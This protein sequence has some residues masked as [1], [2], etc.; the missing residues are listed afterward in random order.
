MTHPAA[1]P[2]PGHEPEPAPDTQPGSGPSHTPAPPPPPTLPRQV[3]PTPPVPPSAAVL[4][5]PP[6][7]APPAAPPRPA[8]SARA[9][10]GRRVEAA[11]AQV[12][13]SSL[14]P[15][16]S[17]VIRIGFAFTWLCFLLREWPH[18]RQLYGPDGPFSVDMARQLIDGNHAFTM[19]VWSDSTVWFEIVYA[20]AIVSSAL[21][22][23]GWRTRTMSVLFM[24]GVLSLQ[25]RSVFLGDGGDNVIH[26]MSTYLVLTRCGQV[27]SLDARR[28]ARQGA[29]GQPRDATGVVLWAGTGLALAA[30]QMFTDSQLAWTANG[31]LPGL[32]WAAFLWGLWCVQALWWLV[33]RYAPGEPRTVL[34]AVAHLIHNGTLLVIMAEVCLIYATAG[35]YK[36]QGSRWQDGTAL[37][38]PLHLDYFSPWPALAD[39]LVKSGIVVMVLTY[40]TVVIQVA[41]PFT[42]FHR[43]IKNVLIAL[44]VLEHVG[45]A[46]LL[47]LPFFSLAMISADAVFLPTAFLIWAGARARRVRQCLLPR[48]FAA[49]GPSGAL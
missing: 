48:R 40:G 6:P 11:F 7:Y 4:A 39:L 25:N 14:G 13:G 27:W 35:W 8:P 2:S 26:L 34:D 46:I 43:K 24:I 29:D 12:T 16:Q 22:M 15:Y 28:A 10:F 41:F 5:P 17:A 42:V 3:P 23:L 20:L 33:R 47:G 45:I 19:L 36:V 21:L 49:G 32:G 37:Y 9:R 38:Y 30:L 1:P 18:R 31:P 44:M